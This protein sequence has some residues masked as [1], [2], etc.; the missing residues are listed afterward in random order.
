MIRFR[1]AMKPNFL[2]MK[3]HISMPKRLVS[4]AIWNESYCKWKH[5]V[6]KTDCSISEWITSCLFRNGIFRNFF[7]SAMYLQYF[8]YFSIRPLYFSI[9]LLHY[10]HQ[11]LHSYIHSTYALLCK[12]LFEWDDSFAIITRQTD[13]QEYGSQKPLMNLQGGL[14]DVSAT[15]FI[16]FTKI[17]YKILF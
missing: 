2:V 12:I 16:K 9:L 14:T 6:P 3:Y 4:L 1:S 5:F 7:I 8:L 17:L 10:V 15:I 13:W 11:K